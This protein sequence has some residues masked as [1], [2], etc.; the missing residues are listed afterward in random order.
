MAPGRRTESWHIPEMYPRFESARSG[1][2]RI[3]GWGRY[4]SEFEAI[5]D[6]WLGSDPTPGETETAHLRSE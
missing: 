6:R 2:D 3:D 1:G 5:H 4:P